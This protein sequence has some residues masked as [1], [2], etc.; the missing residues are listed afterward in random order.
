MGP[1][2]S[3]AEHSEAVPWKLHICTEWEAGKDGAEY[4]STLQI[5]FEINWRAQNWTTSLHHANEELSWQIL[6][7]V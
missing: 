5:A 4:G 1:P 3:E 2:K 6:R 7:N